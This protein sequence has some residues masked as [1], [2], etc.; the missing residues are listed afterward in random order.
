M[1]LKHEQE[2]LLTNPGLV[3]HLERHAI[4]WLQLSGVPS[5]L[6]DGDARLPCRA[7]LWM[8]LR[9]RHATPAAP[10]L[11]VLV[12][13]A[14]ATRTQTFWI[15]ERE[16]RHSNSGN[17]PKHDGHAPSPQP[18]P[19]RRRLATPIPQSRP[20]KGKSGEDCATAAQEER[21][22]TTLPTAHETRAVPDYQSLQQERP[23]Q[24]V[25]ADKGKS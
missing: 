5:D 9:Q 11:G 12:A 24:R 18:A 21:H 7:S 23:R 16:G 13:A 6:H 25:A 14:R 20:R 8:V 4:N 10:L 3:Y 22:L 19:S 15:S 2:L 1:L 17:G